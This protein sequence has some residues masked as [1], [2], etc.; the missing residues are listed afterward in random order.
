MNLKYTTLTWHTQSHSTEVSFTFGSWQQLQ[1]FEDLQILTC[2]LGLQILTNGP[3]HKPNFSA[4]R[5]VSQSPYVEYIQPK[6]NRYMPLFLCVSSYILNSQALVLF[7]LSSI[8]LWSIFVLA[9]SS[10]QKLL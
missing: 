2:S 4:T 3:P 9:T 5:Q 10:R 6:C 1:L 8:L 7:L